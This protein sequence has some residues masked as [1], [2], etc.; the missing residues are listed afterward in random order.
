MASISDHLFAV[1]HPTA[2]GHFPGNPI[3]P[4]AVLLEAVLRAADLAGRHT[5][6]EIRAAKFLHPVRPGDR[7][8]IRCEDLPASDTRFG[9]VKFDCVV[10]HRTVL[11]G[12]IGWLGASV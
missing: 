1:D 5:A 12:S 4:G 11:T 6:Y 8:E 3:I 9:G 10:A 2:E 7:M